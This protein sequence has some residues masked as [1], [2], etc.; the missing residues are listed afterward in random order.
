MAYMR[1]SSTTNPFDG[2]HCS[3]DPTFFRYKPKMYTFAYLFMLYSARKFSG[4]PIIF[5]VT[6][7]VYN[8]VYNVTNRCQRARGAGYIL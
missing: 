2:C 4:K 8:L 7:R 3:N 5:V 1:C 6:N